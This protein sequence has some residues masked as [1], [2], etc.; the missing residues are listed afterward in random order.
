MRDCCS[1]SQRSLGRRSTDS[2][3]RIKG[4]M[5]TAHTSALPFKD[6]FLGNQVLIWAFTL[7]Y[8]SVHTPRIRTGPSLKWKGS[9]RVSQTR[10]GTEP[11]TFTFVKIELGSCYSFVS[12]NCIFPCLYVQEA[13]HKDS[14][15]IDEHRNL[16]C[17]RASKRNTPKGWIYPLIPKPSEKGLESEDIGKKR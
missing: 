8:T 15:D 1:T 7:A 5:H 13:G 16:C 11:Q 9:G 6:N 4:K 3:W 17:K 14:D 10:P 12:K 2:R